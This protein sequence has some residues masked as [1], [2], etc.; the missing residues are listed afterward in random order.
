MIITS[1]DP[2]LSQAAS[3]L[4]ASAYCKCYTPS[5]LAL[6]LI[7]FLAYHRHHQPRSTS[8]EE[9]P[10]P[11][12]SVIFVHFAAFDWNAYHSFLPIISPHLLCAL[13]STFWHTAFVANALFNEG[14][15]PKVCGNWASPVSFKEK[16]ATCFYEPVR[17]KRAIE[18]KLKNSAVLSTP[19]GTLTHQESAD[20]PDGLFCQEVTAKSNMLHY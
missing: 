9:R 1:Y 3:P 18:Q 8:T 6:I 2:L 20:L 13:F 10:V 15:G 14:P 19:K 16:W 4:L 12:L 17:P 5:T 7:R 11:N